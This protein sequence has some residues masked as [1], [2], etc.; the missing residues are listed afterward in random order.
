MDVS[1]YLP[2]WFSNM[3]Q[4]N[5]ILVV[6]VGII[7]I[8]IALLMFARAYPG[9]I[10]FLDKI[11]N[12]LFPQ[13]DSG[14]KSKGCKDETA[15][16]YDED[17]DESDD[18]LCEFEEKSGNQGVGCKDEKALNY[19]E[20]AEE[21]DSSLCRY[22]PNNYLDVFPGDETKWSGVTQVT[23]CGDNYSFLGG[24]EVAGGGAVATREYTNLPSHTKVDISLDAAIIDSWDDNERLIIKV[25]GNEVYSENYGWNMNPEMS[26]RKTAMC[27]N[28][29]TDEIWNGWTDMI[30]AVSITSI[31]HTGSSMKL[32]VTS[33]LNGP[34]TDE[35]WGINNVSVKFY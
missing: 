21:E 27:G 16:N 18:D 3:T 34:A 14:G 29:T 7:S 24:Y 12:K 10:K 25:D 9:K 23:T 20:N 8:C 26:L 15:L 19:D 2:K 13:S 17:A 31:S 32:D 33:S 5:K 6:V 30:D 35:S 22:N 28:K 4:M 11:V 1:K